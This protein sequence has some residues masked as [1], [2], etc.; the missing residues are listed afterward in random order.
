MPEDEVNAGLEVQIL[1][2]HELEAP[3][4]RNAC[5]AL[6]DLVAPRVNAARP[7][8]GF[9]TGLNFIDHRAAIFRVACLLRGATKSR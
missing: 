4:E 1:D 8:Q 3:L 9:D 6:Y 7:D 2:T 5:G